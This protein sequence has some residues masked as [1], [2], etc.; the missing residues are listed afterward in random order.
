MGHT[1]QQAKDRGGVDNQPCTGAAGQLI[2]LLVGGRRGR[3]G[4]R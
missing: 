4:G 2:Q 3:V 1:M